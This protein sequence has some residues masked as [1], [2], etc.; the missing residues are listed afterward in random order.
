[1][2]NASHVS[3]SKG[4]YAL[5][6]AFLEA[7]QRPLA[8]KVNRNL[9]LDRDKVDVNGGSIALGHPIGATG[10]ILNG[11]IVD[12]LERWLVPLMIKAGSDNRRGA[13]ARSAKLRNQC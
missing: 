8:E 10:S 4:E 13:A 2:A 5:L 6:L 12:E 1:V 3:L 11:T 7:L 9:G